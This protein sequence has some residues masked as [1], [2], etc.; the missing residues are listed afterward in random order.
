MQSPYQ[1]P[2]SFD[3][4]YSGIAYVVAELAHQC[5]VCIL[6]SQQHSQASFP[7]VVIKS[8]KKQELLTVFGL[9]WITR[10]GGCHVWITCPNLKMEMGLASPDNMDLV[11]GGS[12]RKMR[13]VSLEKGEHRC[14]AG[15][16]SRGPEHFVSPLLLRNH[17]RGEPFVSSGTEQQ[18]MPELVEKKV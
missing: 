2:L 11:G 17:T 1:A 9:G 18:A 8:V 15:S 16:S 14:W 10:S 12:P 6:F 5:Q 7:A 4:F 3:L 13:V